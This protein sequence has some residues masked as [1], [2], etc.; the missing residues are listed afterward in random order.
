V[1][2]DT[3]DLI[4][5]ALDPDAPA[6][7]GAERAQL[8]DTLRR[9]PA[10]RDLL[11]DIAY[12]ARILHE[13]LNT[14]TTTRDQDQTSPMMP[15]LSAVEGR[16]GRSV[17]YTFRDQG[18][19]TRDQNK[20]SPM[21]SPR[22]VG[23][24]LAAAVITLAL[25]AWFAL[26]DF[27]NPQSEIRN[28]QSFASV[29]TLTHIENAA[30]ADT[31]APMNLGGSLPPGPIHLTSGKAQLMFAS[32]AVVD[33]QGPCEFE[34][35]GPNRGRLTAGTLEASVPEAAQGFTVDLPGGAKIVDRGTAFEVEV[36]I[37][38]RSRVW[39]TEGRVDIFAARFPESLS[40]TAGRHARVTPDGFVR[41]EPALPEPIA[42]WP[43][44]TETPGDLDRALRK[45]DDSATGGVRLWKVEAPI[46]LGRPPLPGPEGLTVSLWFRRHAEG[47]DPHA[48]YLASWGN[49]GSPRP[50]WSIF[51]ASGATHGQGRLG[52]RLTRDGHA[53]GQF[54]T[55]V[56]DDRWHHVVMVL[57]RR[58]GLIH[59][60]LD[61]ASAPWKDGGAGAETA[62]L[63]RDLD[64]DFDL[65]RPLTLG[66]IL[67]VADADKPPIPVT[68]R[69]LR[70]HRQALGPAQVRLL[71]EQ[72]R[73]PDR[74]D[75]APPEPDKLKGDFAR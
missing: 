54:A 14:Q 56:T 43:L 73:R 34:M 39:V 37:D 23:V 3:P 68:V 64:F 62:A 15:V 42:H 63:P 20:T 51:L 53:A 18:S 4:T 21:A 65:D 72:T 69:D 74:V 47:L 52:V 26:P 7:S 30:F 29:A 2:N 60:Y 25:T 31:P 55:P 58:A 10:A 12:H 35:T 67:D 16:R 61:G 19:G 27:S 38:G 6:L 59:G 1:H 70:I 33:L 32:T 17:G 9:D 49:I 40:V 71:H 22:A 28:P 57:D 75:P 46:A 48:T 45:A 24:A 8:N 11:A 36:D 66:P 41:F 13:A 5:R 50:G 44:T